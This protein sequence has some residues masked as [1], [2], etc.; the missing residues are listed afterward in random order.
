M[1]WSSQNKNSYLILKNIISK[2]ILLSIM[3]FMNCIIIFAELAFDVLLFSDIKTKGWIYEQQRKILHP[4]Y[5]QKKKVWQPMLP[6]ADL[7]GFLESFR[8]A[9]AF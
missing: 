5:K 2:I 3:L 9:Q 7:T 6:I 8:Y 4:T 1:I